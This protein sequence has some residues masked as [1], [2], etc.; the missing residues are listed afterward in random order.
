MALSFIKAGL[1]A[2]DASGAKGNHEFSLPVRFLPTEKPGV[3]SAGKRF[4]S[5]E[6]SQRFF[7]RNTAH[8]WRWM[9]RIG[10]VEQGGSI[11]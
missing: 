5:F 7:S 10:K 3:Q 8:R 1:V 11:R 2:L 6:K 9:K 4:Q